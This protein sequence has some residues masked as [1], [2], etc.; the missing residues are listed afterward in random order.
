MSSP[1]HPSAT[2]PSLEIVIACADLERSLAFFTETLGFRLDMIMPAD[3]PRIA[4]LSGYGATLRLQCSDTSF[5]TSQP[6]TTLRLLGSAADWAGFERTVLTSPDGLRVELVNRD[7]ALQAPA[8][9]QSLIISR[10]GADEAMIVGRAAMHYRDLLPGRAGGSYIASLIRIVEGGAVP[11]YVHHHRV[12]FQMIYCKQGWVRVVYEDQGPP[13]VMQ[14]GDCVLQPPAIRHRVLEAS[15]G[16]EVIEIGCPAEHETLRDHVMQL[17]TDTLRADRVFEGQRFVRHIAADAPWRRADAA[18]DVQD[19]A[20]AA[21]TGGAAS[22]RI[23]R[24][25]RGVPC[26]IRTSDRS[27]PGS[28]AIPARGV[29]GLHSGEFLFFFVLEGSVEIASAQP[30]DQT[31]NRGDACMLP[32]GADYS[33]QCAA[34]ARLLE[35]CVPA[36][37]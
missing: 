5:S 20:I 7:A 17:P 16:L 13:F 19:T 8:V 6:A 3:A 1:Q 32:R 10:G 18:H 24:G 14:A 29:S 28:T 37:V 34:G 12:A 31:L 23:V 11:D 22:V 26:A 30:G 4:T 15:A 35:V 9:A 36:R 2:Q 33:V 27:A 21:A 25:V